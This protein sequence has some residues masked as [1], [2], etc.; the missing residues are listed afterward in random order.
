MTSKHYFTEE[1][2]SMMHA[3]GDCQQPLVE[4]AQ[5]IEL[6][7]HQQLTNLIDLAEEVAQS[8]DTQIIGAEDVLFLLRKDKSKL[9]RLI[10]HLYVKDIKTSV[11]DGNS[12]PAEIRMYD[13][14]RS[15]PQSRRVRVCYEYL[16]QLDEFNEY[17]KV[18]NQALFDEIKNQRLRRIDSLTRNMSQTEYVVFS[19]ARQVSF[20]S[21]VKPEK[22]SQWLLCDKPDVKI[23]VFAFEM[24]QYLA[25]ETVAQIV[26]LS[27]L[28]K[29]D[30]ERDHHD[31]LS[32]LITKSA[33][34]NSEKLHISSHC[35]QQPKSFS[36][37]YNDST[38]PTGGHLKCITPSH[39]HEALRRYCISIGPYKEYQHQNRQ[40]SLTVL[41]L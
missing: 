23:S 39:I 31:P 16:S 24:I 3:F 7:V 19:K 2:L 22:F 29:Q 10:N 5:L 37:T 1:L 27:L 13:S 21:R 15:Q 4:S 9:V 34:N 17:K 40:S 36:I 26:D 30:M 6:I 32:V 14:T 8:R 18:F 33:H 41:C 35:Q 38:K 25:H 20:M 28:V 11:N 12:N